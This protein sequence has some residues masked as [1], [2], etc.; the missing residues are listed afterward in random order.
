MSA[1]R[2]SMHG[3]FRGVLRNVSLIEYAYSASWS[4]LARRN[5]AVVWSATLRSEGAHSVELDGEFRLADVLPEGA[6][7]ASAAARDAI[8]AAI[9][10]RMNAL[11][12]RQKI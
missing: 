3:R 7:P 1:M 12:V 9:R 10:A 6:Q 8:D 5:S 11:L 4:T 2:T